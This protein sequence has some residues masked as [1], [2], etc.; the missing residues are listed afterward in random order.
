MG[1]MTAILVTSRANALSSEILTY[2][3]IL[4]GSILLSIEGPVD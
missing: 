4:I 2:S 1:N 3:C